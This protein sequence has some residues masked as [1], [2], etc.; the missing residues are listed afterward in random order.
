MLWAVKSGKGMEK[1]QKYGEKQIVYCLLSK[2]RRTCSR[3]VKDRYENEVVAGETETT[4]TEFG[5]DV[6]DSV[7]L[8]QYTC[9]EYN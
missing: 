2:L 7:F 3:C 4:N 6:A 8:G 5:A 9:K 1:R